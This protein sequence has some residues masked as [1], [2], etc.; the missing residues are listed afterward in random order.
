[1]VLAERN[2]DSLRNGR[3]SR[4]P[5]PNGHVSDSSSEEEGE[6]IRVGRDF[7]AI[8]PECI[9]V[10]ERR[11]EQCS[12]RALLV[13]S[14][15]NDIP[16]QKLDEYISLAKE[17]YGYN[18]EQALGM[19]FWHKHDL[20]RAISD[21]A[22]FTPFPDEWTVEDKV[23]FEQAF[24]FHGK[25]FHRIRQMLPDKSIASLVK[26]YY[27]WKK[28]RSRTSL[29]D[30]Q[31]RKLAVHREEGSEGGSELGS[32]T[33]SDSDDKK[34]TIHR[35]IRRKSGSPPHSAQNSEDQSQ[36]DAADG[37]KSACSN[38]GVA[39]TH[40]HISPKGSMCST[41]FQHWRRTGSVR[42][43]TG[44]VK[45]DRHCHVLLRHK[46]KPPK[47]MYINHDD[48]VAMASGPPAAAPSAQGEQMLK[49]MD[50]EIVSLKRQVQ[51]NKQTLSSFKRKTG[52]GIDEFRPADSTSRINA[53][54]TNDE[55]LL[56][57]QGVRKYG[58]DFRAI[59]EVIG[60]KTEAHMRSFFVNYRR[61]YNLDAVLKEFESENG[62]IV[63]N[64]EKEEKMETDG[65]SSGS[66]PSTPTPGASSPVTVGQGHSPSKQAYS[67]TP[68]T[69]SQASK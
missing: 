9:P 15:T 11:P 23:L 4:G 68:I 64:D 59:A 37:G 36:K 48:L 1:M 39:C 28:T 49:A 16:D 56:A 66:E 55:L 62:P 47:G 12:E 63:D 21:L 3:R 41:C 32:N 5:S 24:Q 14:P 20:E 40:V 53:R 46:R 2:T 34:W 31:V 18:G 22:N 17:K 58:K 33:D 54:W 52:E 65:V 67:K 35:G 45:R 30:R 27:S 50:R 6:K 10:N 25:S 26:Y 19:L 29:M 69:A 51:N 60:T 38:C 57:V 7:Q 8:V 43:T 44:P 61:R 42:P 13:W